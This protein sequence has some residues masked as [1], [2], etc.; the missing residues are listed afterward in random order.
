[1]VSAVIEFGN[2]VGGKTS[3]DDTTKGSNLGVSQSVYSAQGLC[4]HHGNGFETFWVTLRGKAGVFVSRF[5]LGGGFGLKG[6]IGGVER[7]NCHRQLRVAPN[8]NGSPTTHICRGRASTPLRTRQS[9]QTACSCCSQSACASIL[10]PNLGK[11][12]R[13]VSVSSSPSL[14]MSDRLNLQRGPL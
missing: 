6:R 12:D 9:N 3:L 4:A 5:G 13:D 8:H 7:D 1:M 10:G 2:A 11:F 14:N